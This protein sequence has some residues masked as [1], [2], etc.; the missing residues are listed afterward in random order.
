MSFSGLAAW[1]AL[2][3]IAAA[4]GAAAWLFLMKIRPP[5]VNVASLLLWR[6]V[7]D[8]AREQT[9]WERFRKAVSLAATVLLAVAL[10]LA[11]ARPGPRVTA[12][13]RGRLLIVIDSSWSMLTKSPA[14][15]TRWD[16]AIAGA[17]R[18]AASSGG[19]AVAIAT[20]AEG[21]VEGPTTDSALI[22]TA[23]DQLTP[24]GGEDAAWPH[25]GGADAVHFFT[26]G[27]VSRA[28]DRGVIVHSVY[29]AAPNVAVTALAVRP[30][31]T[32]R[33]G[34]EAYLEIANY[35]PA[36]QKVSLTVTRG[37]AVVFDQPVDMNAGEAIRQ[38]IPLDAS[39]DAR[40]R[41][42]VSAPDN[43]LAIDDEAVAWL[44]P[45]EPLD[46]VVV[47]PDPGALTPL[48]SRSEGVKATFVAPNAYRAGDEDV[49]I[50][51]RYAPPEAPAHPALLIAPPAVGWLGAAG[52]EEREPRWVSTG[53][54]PVVA[55]VDP[56]TVDVTRAR[57]IAD[58]KFQVAARS[59]RGTPLVSV[60][61]SP[62]QRLVV[63][64]FTLRDSNFAHAAAFPVLIGNA[65]EWLARPALDS[66]RRPGPMLLPG[67][68]RRVVGPDG[69]PLATRAVGGQVLATLPAPGF[70]LV[71]GGGG[72]SVVSVNVG[73]ADLSN[74]SRTSLDQNATSGAAAAA[75]VGGRP[76]WFYLILVAF[77]LASV[78]WFTW[79]RRITV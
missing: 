40:I 6:K 34:G 14:G 27:T 16:Q 63:L 19:E 65:L 25:V 43:A 1:Q 50:F 28:I 67:S 49:T 41:A 32:G 54:H 62:E 74:V 37:T 71:E 79:L 36:S 33:T 70:Y 3:L 46:V 38:V 76:W 45:A 35:A 52:D 31:A 75:S 18:L 78:E 15:G 64:G 2:A 73:G 60:F 17:R 61:E 26:D 44:T 21:L 12:Q 55:G 51:D 39:G 59:E 7:L 30:A 42:R 11:F 48:L 29:D 5:R 4:G 10:A 9:W 77:V 68:T 8:H 66:P 58:P 13:S 69:R 72:R 23:I 57:A 47:S 22:E 56:L 24:A 20:T 53:R